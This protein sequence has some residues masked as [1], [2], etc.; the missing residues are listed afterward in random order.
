MKIYQTF[1]VH[2]D[3][4]HSGNFY[5]D[6]RLA[7]AEAE[8]LNKCHNYGKLYMEIWKEKT[9]EKYQLQDA[10]GLS[11]DDIDFDKIYQRELLER[12]FFDKYSFL[13]DD[14]QMYR[15]DP[16]LYVHVQEHDVLDTLPEQYQPNGLDIVLK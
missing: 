13:Y 7:E 10:L 2:H 3:S 15:D 14:H 1:G 6:R 11:Y 12:Q 8:Y 5:F 16:G 9:D 4:W